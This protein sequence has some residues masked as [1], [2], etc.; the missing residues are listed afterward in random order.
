MT[1]LMPD[2]YCLRCLCEK[3]CNVTQPGDW[4]DSS[5]RASTISYHVLHLRLF[6]VCV[7]QS[8]QTPFEYGEIVSSEELTA[9]HVSNGLDTLGEI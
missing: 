5:I 3:Y 4:S 2:R 1:D 7:L 9:V 6:A 8:S